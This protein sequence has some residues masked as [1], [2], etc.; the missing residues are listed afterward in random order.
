MAKEV[1]A[2]VRLQI[3]AG[4]ASPA[5]PVGPA[6]GQYGLNI[7]EFVRKYNEQTKDKQGMIIPVEI[8]IFKD[9]TF[10]FKCKTPPVSFLL[11]KE[12]EIEKGSSEPN[13]KK[14]AKIKREKLEKIAK[15]KQPD[16]NLPLPSIIRM[17]EGTA[18][19]MGI[20]IEE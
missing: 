13:K 7:M 19:S 3:K 16:L 1:I 14:V 2:T 4:E 11:K 8:T 15:I 12:V 17:I 20:E 9:R 18:K 6:L 10:T 5:P